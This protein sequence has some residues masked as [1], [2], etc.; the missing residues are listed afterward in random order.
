MCTSC[1]YTYVM[2]SCANEIILR[3]FQ[4][5]WNCLNCFSTCESIFET[6]ESLW[7]R[8]GGFF[9]WK[10]LF[11]NL[12]IDFLGIN[13]K[14]SWNWR[15]KKDLQI[16]QQRQCLQFLCVS[17]QNDMVLCECY[18]NI[19]IYMYICIY[20]RHNSETYDGNRYDW[21]SKS[22]LWNRLL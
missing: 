8:F 6:N 9:L 16:K 15:E 20:W 1:M 21:V 11:Q 2:M 12:S 7:I 17:D 13:S 4:S 5:R 14:R 10:N 18:T 22:Y 3:L 19:Y